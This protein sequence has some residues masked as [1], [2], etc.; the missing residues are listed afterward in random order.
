[1]TSQ[2][3]EKVYRCV[4]EPERIATKLKACEAA[5]LACAQETILSSGAA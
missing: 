3:A 4:N 2:A 5:K 1:V